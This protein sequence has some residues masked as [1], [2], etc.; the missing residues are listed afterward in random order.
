MKHILLIV[1]IFLPVPV[2]G[3]LGYKLDL[4][5]HLSLRKGGSLPPQ[6]CLYLKDSFCTETMVPA[7]EVVEM[8]LEVL[9]RTSHWQIRATMTMSAIGFVANVLLGW[10]IKQMEKKRSGEM[11]PKEHV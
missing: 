1:L 7:F 10:K 11:Q 6:T 8:E 4:L 5:I 9:N 2:P 3:L